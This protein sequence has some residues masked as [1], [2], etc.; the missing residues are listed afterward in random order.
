[1]T[2]TGQTDISGMTASVAA[3]DDNQTFVLDYKNPTTKFVTLEVDKDGSNATAEVAFAIL[4]NG[5]DANRTFDVLANGTNTPYLVVSNTGALDFGTG[6]FA[7]SLWIRR[8]SGSGCGRTSE[9][10][11][12]PS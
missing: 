5:G 12:R 7:L 3:D 10:S 11:A 2:S 8:T 9:R 6:D 1:M 4:Y